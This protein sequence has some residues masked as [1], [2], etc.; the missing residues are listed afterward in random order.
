MAEG[1]ARILRRAQGRS[2]NSPR[3][4]GR[5]LRQALRPYKLLDIRND[6]ASAAKRGF[7]RDG[8]KRAML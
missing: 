1:S 3:P 2:P 7:A 6:A 8:K 5:N 4:D